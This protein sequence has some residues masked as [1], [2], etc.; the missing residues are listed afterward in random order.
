MTETL[1]IG[2]VSRLTGV[3]A[4]TIRFYEAEGV[5]A[6]P[7][8]SDAG[9]RRYSL[10]DVRRLRLARRARLLGL[11]LADV[12]V[13]VDQAFRSDCVEFGDQLLT[14]IADQ[15]ANIDARIA[16]LKALKVELAEL[17]QH[18]RH[19]LEECRPGQQVAECAYCPM[20]D[21]KGGETDDSVPMPVR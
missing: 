12:K 11:A 4:K 19:N 2:Q 16:E 20:I 9:Y 18:V 5:I 3:P 6:P 1:T 8:R 13:L 21:E 7:S 15:Q 17:E 10:L 14:H